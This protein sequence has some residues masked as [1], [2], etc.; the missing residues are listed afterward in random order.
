MVERGGHRDAGEQSTD[1]KDGEDGNGGDDE[2]AEDIKDRA[3]GH[4]GAGAAVIEDA[5]DADSGECR[6]E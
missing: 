6:D 5:A 2:N 1:G 3:C 4:H